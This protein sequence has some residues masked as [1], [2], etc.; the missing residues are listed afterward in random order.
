[1]ALRDDL[2]DMYVKVGDL[3][4]R[5]IEKG[6]GKP[7][8]CLHGL[9]AQLSGDQWL[10]SIDA[11]STVSHVYCP[12]LP[13]W[14]LTTLK[15][16]R[17]SFQDYVD[18]IDGFCDALGLTEVDITGQSLG[19]WLAALYAYYHPERVRRVILVGN[20]GLNPPLP[21]AAHSFNMPTRDQL[22]TT[23]TREWTTYVP[24]TEAQLDELE[25]RMNMPG[26]KEA[27]EG[28]LHE[29]HNEDNRAKY[30]LREKLPEMQQ[31][32]LVVWGDDAPGIKLQYGIEAFQL[33]PKGRLVVLYGGN[34][35]A[36]AFRPREF[37]TQ[38]ITFLTEEDVAAAK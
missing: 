31:P 11:L 5:Y 10:V 26:R 1:M 13:G 6:S 34:H 7:L 12:D 19:G 8:I 30:S 16:D 25:R 37:E 18:F 4:V 3:D 28:V 2:K 35:N 20:A 22:R 33:A 24:I 29:V 14:G 32:I 9:N 21:N 23:L 36:M 15:P 38:A 17:H 27:Y